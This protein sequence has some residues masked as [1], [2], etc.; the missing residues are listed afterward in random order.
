MLGALPVGSRSC[1]E[2][3]PLLFTYARCVPSVV[4]K[5]ITLV[6]AVLAAMGLYLVAPLLW[7]AIFQAYFAEPARAVNSSA[8]NASVPSHD[9]VRFLR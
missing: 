1:P 4:C 3:D 7:T 5:A 8:A 6:L 9:E 2:A